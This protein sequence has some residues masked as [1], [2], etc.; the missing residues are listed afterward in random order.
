MTKELTWQSK[1]LKYT[2]VHRVVLWDCG[3]SWG[4]LGNGM[5][6]AHG[7][8]LVVKLKK[9]HNLLD[10]RPN[11]NIGFT[12]VLRS[13]VVHTHSIAVLTKLTFSSQGFP[14]FPD[15][16]GK[17]SKIQ[18]HIGDQDSIPNSLSSHKAVLRFYEQNLKVMAP[19]LFWRS[20]C[21]VL[22]RIT[23]L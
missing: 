4:G 12:F 14:C 11:L 3:P 8:P 17:R 10:N 15:L 2:A 1:Q 6:R 22:R 20:S 18:L 23:I 9:G 13:T 19:L 7:F 5:N 16:Y 21:G